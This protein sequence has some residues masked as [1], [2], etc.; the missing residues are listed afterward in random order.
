[1]AHIGRLDIAHSFRQMFELAGQYGPELGEG[2]VPVVNIADL[3]ET[4][5]G[6]SI[7]FVGRANINA[8]A[9]EYSYAIIRPTNLPIHSWASIDTIW[10]YTG[11]NVAVAIEPYALS[12][13][14]VLTGGVAT[15]MQ[16]ARQ[17]SLGSATGRI[18]P[19][20][21]FYKGTAAAVPAANGNRL[22]SS[23]A[24]THRVTGRWAIRRDGALV[25]ATEAV[26]NALHVSIQ[27]RIHFSSAK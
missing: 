26:N 2:I 24:E 7:P 10:V 4:P 25:I 19:E 3:E 14:P 13:I 18:V 17:P 8:F 21:D 12:S 22:L 5:F 23:I 16:G 6:L 15:P 11:I 9:A 1:M 20:V 27:G